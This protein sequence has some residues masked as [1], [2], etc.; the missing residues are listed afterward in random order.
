MLG[1]FTLVLY[2]AIG[3]L[4]GGGGGGGGGAQAHQMKT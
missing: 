4:V 1:E 3:N 2:S